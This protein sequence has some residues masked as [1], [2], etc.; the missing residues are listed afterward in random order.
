MGKTDVSW[1]IFSLLFKSGCI[2]GVVVD[3]PL[4]WDYENVFPGFYPKYNQSH[5]KVKHAAF[6]CFML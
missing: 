3:T 5:L 6:C 2:L 1:E 4:S